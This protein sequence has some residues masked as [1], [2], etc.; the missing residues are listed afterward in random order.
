MAY[1][2]ESGLITPEHLRRRQAGEPTPPWFTTPDM[3]T[4]R[5][6]DD[7]R[8]ILPFTPPVGF[9]GASELVTPAGK[10][11]TN[12]KKARE[13]S[14]S[15]PEKLT[16][17]IAARV[18]DKK[19]KPEV[20]TAIHEAG[21]L[22]LEQLFADAAA[23]AGHAKR[24]T[25]DTNDMEAIFRQQRLLDDRVGLGELIHNHLSREYVEELL[26][27]AKALVHAPALVRGG[28][29]SSATRASAGSAHSR[30]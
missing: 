2:E 9:K 23:Y 13:A 17:D 15:F 27:V 10:P 4:V 25:V 20:I 6:K 11:R 18:T 29:R 22:H 5:F 3:H 19:L 16:Q 8:G 26:P 7:G 24:R 28:A 21:M 14:V 30:S 1:M 12:D